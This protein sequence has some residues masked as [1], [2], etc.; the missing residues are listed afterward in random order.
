MSELHA[1]VV[2]DSEGCRVANSELA[3]K[4]WN[5][6][7]IDWKPSS[8]LFRFYGQLACVELNCSDRSEGSGDVL[9]EDGPFLDPFRTR[10]VAHGRFWP[11]IIVAH[12]FVA[13]SGQ[14]ARFLST[15]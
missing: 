9:G 6:L 7:T 8:S 5:V 12:D 13:D 3:D 10:F 15:F 4:H 1:L 11:R 14:V 2:A